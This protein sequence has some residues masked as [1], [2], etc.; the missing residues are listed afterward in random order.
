MALIQ[1]C[2]T[3]QVIDRVCT[4]LQQHLVFIFQKLNG[5]SGA[6]RRTILAD[7]KRCDIFYFQKTLRFWG[8]LGINTRRNIGCLKGKNKY[9]HKKNWTFFSSREYAFDISE[10]KRGKGIQSC[11]KLLRLEHPHRTPSFCS[12]ANDHKTIDPTMPQTANGAHH[13]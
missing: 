10:W 11:P 8:M 5:H 6:I 3:M 1:R 2:L 4:C 12:N 13:N 9:T 7:I